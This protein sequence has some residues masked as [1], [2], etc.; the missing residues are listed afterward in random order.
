[1]NETAE[2]HAVAGVLPTTLA[3]RL[4]AASSVMIKAERLLM[5][6]PLLNEITSY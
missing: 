4:A 3:A 2:A 5:A 6:P 1:M